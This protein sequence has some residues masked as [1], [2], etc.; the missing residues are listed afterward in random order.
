M[1]N[2]N[3]CIFLNIGRS[4]ELFEGTLGAAAMYSERTV[5]LNTLPAVSIMPIEL[6]LPEIPDG[7]GALGPF[8]R[9][10]PDL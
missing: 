2:S 4:L 5:T 9:F 3:Q 8:D 1:T 10:R 7:T 6:G